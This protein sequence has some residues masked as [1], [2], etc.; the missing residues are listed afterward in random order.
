M[1]LLGASVESASACADGTLSLRF[2]DG[3]VI[4]CYDDSP[5]YEA[6]RVRFGDEEVVV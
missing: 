6:Y 5:L 1:Q 3:Q 2:G 4:T